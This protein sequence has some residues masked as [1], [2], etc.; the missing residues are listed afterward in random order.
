VEIADKNNKF[1]I[2]DL[3]KG[4]RS[5]TMGDVKK[6]Y[7]AKGGG[8]SEFWTEINETTLNERL[9]YDLGVV[10]ENEDLISG[11][12]WIKFRKSPIE[13]PSY[14]L[15]RAISEDFEYFGY[16]NQEPPK[17]V[18]LMDGS[19]GSFY[20]HVE[21][22][23]LNEIM[24]LLLELPEQVQ[25]RLEER[26]IKG[27]KDL[28]LDTYGQSLDLR[29]SQS[30]D[31]DD[32][33]E[34][35]KGGMVDFSVWTDFD[36][37]ALKSKNGSYLMS[38]KEALK[39]AKEYKKMF[40][41]NEITIRKGEIITEYDFNSKIFKKYAVGGGVDNK[42]EWIAIYSRGNGQ[43]IVVVKAKDKSEAY[44]EAEMSRGN[45]KLGSDWQ[46]IDIYE[47]QYAKGGGIS[48]LDDL[49]RG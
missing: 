5:R 13:M 40:P 6:E 34:Y 10:N 1:V 29:I 36:K 15:K 3:D 7:L 19:W 39:M 9:P 18:S 30:S 17:R 11:N 4:M 21:N 16:G 2:V 26:K 43:Q 47:S 46:M 23:T 24:T 28:G 48:G 32:D 42:K 31:N 25:E 37:E 27:Y 8:V 33:Y 38:E 41:T 45:Y 49:L 20:I 22:L 35:A 44:R 14:E 12:I